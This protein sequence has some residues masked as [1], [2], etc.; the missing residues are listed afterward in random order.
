MQRKSFYRRF[1][2]TTK[3]EKDHTTPNHLASMVKTKELSL[4]LR[5]RTVGQRD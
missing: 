2:S 5:K 4:D 3:K 1:V